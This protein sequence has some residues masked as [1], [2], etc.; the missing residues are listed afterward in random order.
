[1]NILVS[2]FGD[3]VW[4]LPV[5]EVDRLRAIFPQHHFTD[6]RD[7]DALAAAVG[8]A[9]V[10]LT[11]RIGADLLPI[12][13]RLRWIQS[14]AAGVGLMMN[15]KMRESPVVLTNS[16]GLHVDP[17]A[18]HVVGVT[19]ALARHLHAAVRNQA[20]A[21]WAKP[22]MASFKTLRGRRMGIVGFGAIGSAV[23]ARV[24]GLGMLVSAL[25]RTGRPVTSPAVDRAYSA[26]Q[27]PEL[28]AESDVVLISAPST[29]ETAGLI[30]RR[31]LRLMKR[32]AFL[33]NVSRGRLVREAELAEELACGTIAG[34]ALDVFEREPLDAASPLWR[35]PNV[36]V[37]PHT[38]AF[39]PEYWTAAVDFFADN[40]RR[41][42]AGLPLV[43]VVDK[44]AGY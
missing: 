39:S 21:V 5:E 14:P 38:S 43:N 11:T 23:A 44:E 13:P 32:T 40:L 16:R 9:D 10:A 29:P 4:T 35:L 18:E 30:G 34:A 7:P 2:V 24:A 19:I 3:R 20:Q 17:I 41:F 15:P 28:L 6:A 31:E 22:A 42:E 36:I 25:T 33:V 12:A 37:T 8:E 1:M 26:G 27:L